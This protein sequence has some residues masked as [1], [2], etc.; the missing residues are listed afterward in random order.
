MGKRA[1]S[2]ALINVIKLCKEFT[3]NPSNLDD[4]GNALLAEYPG[5]TGNEIDEELGWD[6]HESGSRLLTAQE[7]R[8][9]H[10]GRNDV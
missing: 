4:V 5:L 8:A 3:H 2:S 10:P 1:Y 9:G 6:A 7:S